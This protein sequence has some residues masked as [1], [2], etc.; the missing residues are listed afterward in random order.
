MARTSGRLRPNPRSE[1]GATLIFVAIAIF[2]LTAMSAFVLDFGVLWLSRRQ[3]QNSADAGALAGATALTYDGPADYTASGPGYQS[4]L[5]TAQTNT[6][7]GSQPGV[8]V[9]I[10]PSTTWDHPA[11]EKC[12]DP[13][14]GCVQVDVYRDG[15]HG[16]TVLPTYFA[17]L[18]G[19]TSQGIKATATAM[20]APG[21]ASRCLRPW[22]IPDKWTDAD[23]DGQYTSPPDSYTNP[24]YT[25]ADVGTTVTFK[26]GDPAGAISP[27]DYYVVDIDPNCTG[28][29]CYR[30][31]ISQCV[32]VEHAI[33]GTLRTEPGSMVGPT[34]Q[35]VD[36]L[37][38]EDP[39]ATWNGTAVVNS[40]G[41]D[42]NS[43]RIIPLA[44]FSV[45]EFSSLARQ[46]GRFDLT[47]VNMM[48]FFL[49]GVD[50]GGNVT[51][52]LVTDSGDWSGG[53]GSPSSNAAFLK[54]IALVR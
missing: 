45:V 38:A 12:G 21:N 35:G 32:D 47:I 33:G 24:G 11:P 3:A 22:M 46:S 13:P 37:I 43:P 18:L 9:D 49:T 7:F 53:A 44:M 25:L 19:M 26:P 15:T 6:V 34:K 20:T 28:G 31:S 14:V 48:G 1:L 51:G 42:A 54:V 4:A 16:S 52:V 27:S 23:G 5:L 2:V 10:D 30:D 36:A 50:S 29:N 39:T 40:S 17:N 41:D 8:H